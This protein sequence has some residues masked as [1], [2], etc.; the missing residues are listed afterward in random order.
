M[1][2]TN[3]TRTILKFVEP[4]VG[5]F[6]IGLLMAETGWVTTTHAA[7]LGAFLVAGFAAYYGISVGLYSWGALFIGNL[8]YTGGLLQEDILLQLW[9]FDVLLYWSGMLLAAALIGG[10]TSARQERLEDQRYQNAALHKDIIELESTV[11]TVVAAKDAL[12]TKLLATDNQTAELVELFK[13]LDHV[14]PRFVP[15]TVVQQLERHLGA[16][17]VVVHECTG[18]NALK[19]IAAS[20]GSRVQAISCEAPMIQRT[21]A[22]GAP[23]LRGQADGQDAPSLAG[24]VLVNDQL[25]YVITLDLPFEQ[26]S[27]QQLNLFGWF[28]Q[29]LG[30]RMET[31]ALREAAYPVAPSANVLANV[32]EG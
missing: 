6:L 16:S 26:L 25:A 5:V 20:A 8:L 23:I 18:D 1:A 19:P 9:Q 12:K 30:M 7:M 11:D 21:I 22:S 10:I 27:Q 31:E 24:A 15:A 32:L 3:Q 4:L 28:T 13:V 29:I 14:A 17:N 2:K